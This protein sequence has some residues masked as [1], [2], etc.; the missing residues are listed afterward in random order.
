MK[1][2]ISLVKMTGT[3]KSEI[4][5]SL[6]RGEIVA[7]ARERLGI[8][9]QYYMTMGAYDFVLVFEAPSDEAMAELLLIIGQ[10]GAINTET[11]PAFTDRTYMPLLEKLFA[12]EP[13]NDKLSEK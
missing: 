13:N 3:G 5:R 7:K 8:S 2:F 6:K 4:T 11:T 12:I 1:T 10:I 9:M